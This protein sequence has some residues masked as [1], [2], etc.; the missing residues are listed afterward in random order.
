MDSELGLTYNFREHDKKLLK[1]ISQGNTRST[2]ATTNFSRMILLFIYSIFEYLVSVRLGLQEIRATD[3]SSFFRLALSMQKVKRGHRLANGK[4]CCNLT[5]MLHS[6]THFQ[7]RTSSSL[8]IFGAF[9]LLKPTH[10]LISKHSSTFTL[11]H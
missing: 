1:F 7:T 9:T 2:S 4:V 10:A 11:K 3:S 5:I 6:Q 8:N